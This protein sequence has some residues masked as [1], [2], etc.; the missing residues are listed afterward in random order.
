MSGRMG[1]LPGPGQSEGRRK[2]AGKWDYPDRRAMQEASLADWMIAGRSKGLVRDSVLADHSPSEL[3][4]TTSPRVLGLADKTR[5]CRASR[6]MDLVTRLS[7]WQTLFE[8]S[9]SDN[10]PRLST[11]ADSLQGH[12]PVPGC[13]EGVPTELQDSNETL[14]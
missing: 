10:L 7:K 11:S 6:S 1:C 9:E 5:T 8:I 14:R 12:T 2:H 3:S 4:C 13:L